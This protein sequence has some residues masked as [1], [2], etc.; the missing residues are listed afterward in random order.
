MGPPGSPTVPE[1]PATDADRQLAVAALRESA[2]R[3]LLTLDELEERLS[4]VL[5]AATVGELVTLTW[6]ATAAVPAAPRVRQSIWRRVGFGYHATVYGL[7]NGMLVGTWAMTGHGFFWPFFPIM[8]WGIGLGVH[9]AVAAAAPAT[10][11]PAS[12]PGDSD[13][14]RGPSAGTPVRRGPG[15][16]RAALASGDAGDGGRVRYVAVMFA[17]VADSTRLNEALGDAAWNRVR[18]RHLELVRSSVAGHAGAEVST[19]GDGLFARFDT[20]TAAVACAIELQR[21]AEAQHEETGFAPRVRIGIHAGEAIEAEADLVGNMVNLAA[22]V[23]SEAEPG[24]ILI[25]EPVADRTGDRF[26]LD[27]CGLRTLKGVSRPR[28]L[29][30]VRW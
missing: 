28:H 29:L 20:P 13:A 24:Q 9:A 3:G 10:P 22:R 27:D 5:Q 19:Q 16:R 8:G 11:G 1:R 2:G 6:D 7:T 25:T 23:T 12:P 14:G 26:T 21:R 18:V 30:S 15:A 4:A 17:D